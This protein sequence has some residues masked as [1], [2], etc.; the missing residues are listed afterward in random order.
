MKETQL[1]VGDECYFTEDGD[2]D[3]HPVVIERI[4]PSGIIM[5]G[6]HSGWRSDGS[7]K[8]SYRKSRS[9]LQKINGDK[10]VLFK[11]YARE[12]R[13]RLERT[14]WRDVDQKLLFEFV[15]RLDGYIGKGEAENT[16]YPRPSM[17]NKGFG[18]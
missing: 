1:K 9:S 6:K 7:P 12:A 4:T 14:S 10:E 13:M 18:Y 17:I 15:D 5:T 3:L 8:G 2:D 11:I 16:E